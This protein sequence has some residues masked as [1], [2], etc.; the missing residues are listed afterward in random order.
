MNVASESGDTSLNFYNLLL[1]RCQQEF[2]KDR[3][4]DEAL[5]NRQKELNAARDVRVNVTG[6]GKTKFTAD[7][8]FSFHLRCTFYNCWFLVVFK[9]KYVLSL[10]EEEQQH[11]K[12]E[13]EA[14]KSKAHRRSLGFIIF[15][16]ELFKAEM[17]KESIMHECINKLLNSCLEDSFEC[18]CK[19]LPTCGKRLDTEEAKVSTEVHILAVFILGYI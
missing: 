8:C 14:M 7:K 11:L 18:F 13:V 6:T 4:D 15:F 1:R 16:G 19:L 12:R 10:Q 17:L 9:F 2:L 5:V 3:N